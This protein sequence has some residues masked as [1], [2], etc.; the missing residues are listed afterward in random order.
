MAV[1]HTIIIKNTLC[2]AIFQQD[3]NM[4]FILYLKKSQQDNM[5]LDNNYNNTY[6]IL[7]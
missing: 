6:G 2:Q 5:L 1:L 7:C 3:V 4:L